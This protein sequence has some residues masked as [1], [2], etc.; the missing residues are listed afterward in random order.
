M[1]VQV[2]E[3]SSPVEN[4][5]PET[6][7]EK[8]QPKPKPRRL[9]QREVDTNGRRPIRKSFASGIFNIIFILFQKI[10]IFGAAHR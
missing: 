7:L 2:A 6:V 4:V 8:E 1:Y 9:K 3:P 10:T 5:N